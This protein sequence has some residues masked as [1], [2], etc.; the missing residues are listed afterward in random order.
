MASRHGTDLALKYNINIGKRNAVCIEI[1]RPLRKPQ[2]GD[3]CQDNQMLD[4]FKNLS[5]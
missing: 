5:V 4:Q 1:V 3:F 2:F